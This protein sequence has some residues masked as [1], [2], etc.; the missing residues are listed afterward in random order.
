MF[1]PN[2]NIWV[3]TSGLLPSR[4]ASSGPKFSPEVL[5]MFDI[6]LSIHRLW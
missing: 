3:C 6:E 1:D 4:S 5:L 2:G